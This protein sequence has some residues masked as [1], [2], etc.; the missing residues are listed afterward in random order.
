MK[1]QDWKLNIGKKRRYWWAANTL[2]IMKL[3]K[4]TQ[5]LELRTDADVVKCNRNGTNYTFNALKR[6]R[7]VIMK[8]ETMDN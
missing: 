3:S 7:K 8:P 4:Q 2:L 5:M 6:S 1:N